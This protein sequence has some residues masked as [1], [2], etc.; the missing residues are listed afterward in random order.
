[1]EAHGGEV[2]A[3]P[4]VSL[5]TTAW[6]GPEILHRS[7]RRVYDRAIAAGWKV[8]GVRHSC[9]FVGDVQH[10]S[11]GFGLVDPDDGHGEADGVWTDDRWDNGRHY[12]QGQLPKRI[13]ARQ[14]AALAE[15]PPGRYA[16]EGGDDDGQEP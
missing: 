2:T 7:A 16:E 6:L 4:V 13:G 15:L 1:M 12:E 14:F 5:A 3:R 9:W 10:V 11:A 8:P